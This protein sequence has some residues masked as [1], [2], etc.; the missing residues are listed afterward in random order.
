VLTRDN[1]VPI[2][3]SSDRELSADPTLALVAADPDR[4]AHRRMG[5]AVV[6]AVQAKGVGFVVAATWPG[7]RA[8]ERR[9]E[10]RKDAPRFCPVC[11]QH[12]R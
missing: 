10:R 7:S 11:R 9:L 4:R 3:P 6:R 1:P 12:R 5:A 2:G 8:L